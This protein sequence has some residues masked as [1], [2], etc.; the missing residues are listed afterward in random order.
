MP[1]YG[2]V[3]LT[4]EAADA[5][6]RWVKAKYEKEEKPKQKPKPFRVWVADKIG[7]SAS[8]YYNAIKP[9][10][11]MK[12]N[13]TSILEAFEF[14][15]DGNSIYQ[16]DRTDIDLRTIYTIT[17]MRQNER[18]EVCFEPLT[19]NDLVEFERDDW[20]GARFSDVWRELAQYEIAEKLTLC[21]GTDKPLLGIVQVGT[22]RMGEGRVTPLRDS[23]LEVAPVHQFIT[24]RR[25]YKGIGRV[26][27]A[28]L[29]EASR[30][31]GAE[32][33]LLVRPVPSSVP[34][35]RKLGFQDARIPHY[36][37]VG[38]QGANAIFAQATEAGE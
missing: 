5:L 12:A 1:K 38:V 10:P 30:E 13:L 11:M 37:Q 29:I 26:L 25:S 2:E 23:L 17:D 19:A 18:V 16:F 6:E 14:P 27:V 35:Y 7:N 9:K 3:Q 33:R 4:N 8:N 20:Q 31:K 15:F 28:R 34:F 32:G 22:V 24:G 21:A 36:M